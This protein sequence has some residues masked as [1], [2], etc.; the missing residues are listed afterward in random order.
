MKRKESIIYKRYTWPQERS[1]EQGKREA[2]NIRGGES[3]ASWGRSLRHQDSP[4]GK[5][6]P[7][8]VV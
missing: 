1:Y 6:V 3:V 4:L 5:V 2:V 7:V 8:Q